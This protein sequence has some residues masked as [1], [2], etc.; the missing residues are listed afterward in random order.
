MNKIG[1]VRQV[2][3]RVDHGRP[4]L[5]ALELRML[6]QRGA[7]G[8]INFSTISPRHSLIRFIAGSDTA[9]V[10]LG[11]VNENIAVLLDYFAEVRPEDILQIGTPMC[12][13][14]QVT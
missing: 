1:Q 13:I 6:S 2:F 8:D 7:Q 11:E 9:D 3:Q 5:P 4:V 12:S 10:V 14:R